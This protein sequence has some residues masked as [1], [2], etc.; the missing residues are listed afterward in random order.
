MALSESVTKDIPEN[1]PEGVPEDVMKA[2]L[3]QREVRLRSNY[4][5]AK[6]K[7][8]SDPEYR[9]KKNAQKTAWATAKYRN[10]PEYA[11]RI[12]QKKR[13][14]YARRKAQ[15]LSAASEYKENSLGQLYNTEAQ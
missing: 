2:A 7:Y 13:D 1:I 4:A 11:E 5:Y 9:A 10:D 6:R 3:H 14:D 15:S 12:K 8:A